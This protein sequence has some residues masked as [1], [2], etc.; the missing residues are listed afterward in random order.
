MPTLGIYYWNF[1]SPQLRLYVRNAR[2]LHGVG[3]AFNTAPLAAG[4]QLRLM[5]FGTTISFLEN[6]VS[7]ISVTGQHVHRGRAGYH[8]PRQLAGRQLVRRGYCGLF[9]WRDCLGV[10]RDGGAAG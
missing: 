6:G 9:G 3:N 5:A 10:V 2:H 7:Q 8:G 4:T 1:G